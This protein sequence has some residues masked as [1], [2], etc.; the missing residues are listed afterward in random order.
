MVVDISVLL[1]IHSLIQHLT[2]LD[3][4]LAQTLRGRSHIALG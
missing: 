1:D 4:E 3:A 2:G